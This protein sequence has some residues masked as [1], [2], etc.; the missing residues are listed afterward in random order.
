MPDGP[1]LSALAG[2]LGPAVL[3]LVDHLPGTMFCVKG[4]DGRYIAVNPTFVKRTNKRSRAEVLGR[5]AGEL[6]VAELAD[7]YE[8]QD[9]R[10]HSS[11]RPLFNELELIRAP[12]GPFRWHVTAKVPLRDEDGRV[13]GVVSMSQDVGEGAADDRTMTS[14]GAVVAH[15]RAHLGENVTS[16]DLARVAGCSV[17]TLE[18]RC[19]RVFGRS[20]GQL[21]L[22]TRIDVARGLLTGS[23]MPLAQIADLCGY[24]D[25]AGFSRTFTRLVGIP[26]G[27]Y[28]KSM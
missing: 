26:P 27:R 25:Q 12:G 6:F 7:R 23:D 19:R 22:S 13:T 9:A 17:D 11:G 14:L 1:E 24:A 4:A 20:P 3:E 16:Q 15:I 2:A 10:V 8:E 28:R 5:R 21:I 18:R